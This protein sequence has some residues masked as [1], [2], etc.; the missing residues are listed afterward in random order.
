MLVIYANQNPPPCTKPRSSTPIWRSF[1]LKF[2]IHDLPLFLY[3]F[4]LPRETLPLQVT[5]LWWSSPSYRSTFDLDGGTSDMWWM[6]PSI[7]WPISSF[8]LL[9]MELGLTPQGMRKN[10]WVSTTRSKP[11]RAKCLQ[12]ISPLMLQLYLLIYL[13][14]WF[15][16]S[17]WWFFGC[18]RGG[19]ACRFVDK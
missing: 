16:M 19:R 12:V 8:P 6:I 14:S 17:R 11:R 2:K 15:S 13:G 18:M 7:L 10:P 5:R 3:I 1:H 9:W 4:T